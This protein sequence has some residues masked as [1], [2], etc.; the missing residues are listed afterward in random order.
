M[1]N[2]LEELD[3]VNEWFL[4]RDTRTLYFM[5]N[6]TMPKTF[7]AGQTP[8]IVSVHGDAN[9]PVHDLTIKG[10]TFS[11]TPNNF[12]RRFE[13]PSGGDY[14]IHRGAALF[15]QGT[16]RVLIE[17]CTF[18]H[19]GSNALVV[20][21]YNVNTTIAYNSFRWL[22]ESAIILQGETAG[23]DGVSNI[24]QPTRTHVEG[25]I[26]RDFS[27]YI[28]QGDAI[29]QSLV[30]SSVWAANLGFNSPRSIFNV[31]SSH[32]PCVPGVCVLSY[33]VTDVLFSCCY[34]V[35]TEE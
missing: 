26:A 15:L 21:N 30:R 2:I 28:K 27:N 10:I 13:A 4:D 1:H 6:G 22:G 8:N 20:S 3:D 34:A 23:I 35:V 9:L 11:H 17:D 12:L 24:N 32:I 7:I 29:F 14:S 33:P 16:E 5:P 18:T 25:N 19:L 31:V